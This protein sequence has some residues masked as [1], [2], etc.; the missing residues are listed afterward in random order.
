MSPD[1]LSPPIAQSSG[2]KDPDTAA[3][4]EAD[5]LR[6]LDELA[7][8]L[9]ELLKY[10]RAMPIECFAF[11]MEVWFRAVARQLRALGVPQAH[12][13]SAFDLAG[14][15]FTALVEQLGRLETVSLEVAQDFI[16]RFAEFGQFVI[17][18]GRATHTAPERRQ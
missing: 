1:L 18:S 12:I 14:R 11:C 16:V 9:T 15:E 5:S 6:A 7:A 2:S 17:A 3:W 8:D 10:R 13:G 4:S